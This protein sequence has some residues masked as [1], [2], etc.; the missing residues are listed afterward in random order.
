MS[1]Q[2]NQQL[3]RKCKASLAD[4]STSEEEHREESSNN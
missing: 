2:L 3:C 1:K 4:H